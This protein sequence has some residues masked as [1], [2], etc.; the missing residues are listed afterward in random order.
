MK[1][2][3]KLAKK[4]NIE[5]DPLL[6]V[7]ASPGP[8]PPPPDDDIQYYCTCKQPS[9]AQE[10]NEMPM[11]GCDKCENWF[12]LKCLNVENNADL[13]ER[14]DKFTCPYCFLWNV[15][16]QSNKGKVS[17]ST[18]WDPNREL[19]VGDPL[20]PD[21]DC[22]R[23]SYNENGFP[24]YDIVWMRKCARPECLEYFSPSNL[25]KYCS[26]ECG[27]TVAQMRLKKLFLSQEQQQDAGQ[28]QGNVE[29][30]VPESQTANVSME[31]TSADLDMT[32]REALQPLAAL[33]AVA[34]MFSILHYGSDHICGYINDC[35]SLSL[36][37]IRELF[38][39][40]STADKSD[41]ERFMCTS[42]RNKCPKHGRTKITPVRKDLPVILENYSSATSG[43][44]TEYQQRTLATD[45]KHP[46][47]FW[48]ILLANKILIRLETETIT[49]SRKQQTSAN[50]NQQDNDNVKLEIRIRNDDDQSHEYKQAHIL[51]TSTPVLNLF[52]DEDNDIES[53]HL[54]T[55][56]TIIMR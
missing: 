24:D 49:R 26:D 9:T 13:L 22:A 12:H 4:L 52:E 28:I 35:I 27:V 44:F 19:Q 14:I 56:A 33:V 2:S 6:S 39:Q 42:S 36:P 8:L 18:D 50:Q 41:L 29:I 20:S 51:V 11:I 34:N 53:Q 23:L 30:V 32:E 17:T 45:M 43:W 55:G 38:Q 25:S 3:L 5:M 48:S 21:S 47:P 10:S 1:R 46:L 16:Q 37:D 15:E 54:N 40:Y 7:I 31:P